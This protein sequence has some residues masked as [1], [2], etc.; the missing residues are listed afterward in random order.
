MASP[1]GTCK[2]D[3]SARGAHR[4][5]LQCL[6]VQHPISVRS[7]YRHQRRRPHAVGV[8]LLPLPD[9]FGTWAGLAVA[10]AAGLWC[11]SNPLLSLSTYLAHKRRLGTG[12]QL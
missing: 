7:I 3:I 6:T 4:A 5:Q 11:G 2:W 12:G 9:P 1:L 10:G 8:G